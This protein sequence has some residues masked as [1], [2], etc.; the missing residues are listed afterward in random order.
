METVVN[1]PG[2]NVDVP[3]TQIVLVNAWG[4]ET[5]VAV[6]VLIETIVEVTGFKVDVP[7]K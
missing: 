6:L 2:V 4:V 3:V 7:V 5:T 1:V